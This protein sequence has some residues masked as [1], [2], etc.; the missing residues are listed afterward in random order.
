M[1]EAKY[2]QYITKNK[3]KFA[4]P[5][6]I[7][8]ECTV[9][10]SGKAPKGCGMPLY[11]E[12]GNLYVDSSDSHYF[13]KG[14]TGSKKSRVVGNNIINTILEAKENA[15]INDPKGELYRRT[16]T[17]AKEKGYN[18][19]VLNFRDVTKS[20]G[21]NPLSLAFD[22]YSNGNMPEAEQT[23]NDF[24]NAVVAPSVTSSD[25]FWSDM[26]GIV[27]AY[28]T[29]CLMDSVPIECFNMSNIIQMTHEGNASA[30]RRILME[31]DPLS[32]A[33]ICMHSVLD[34]QAARTSSC[35]YATLKQA[36]IP[37]TQNKALLELLCRRDIQLGDLV[38]PKTVI[39]IIYP[40][41][42]KSLG[43]LISLFFTQCYQYL[44]AY[45][46]QFSD[47]K[48][49][50]RVNFVLDE[51]SNLPPIDNFENCI[52]K[53]RGHNIRYFLFCQSYSQ[54]KNKYK[55]NAQTILSN[56]E[57]VVFPSKEYD[58]MEMVSRLCGKE[59]DYYGTEHDLVSVSEMQHLRKFRDGA[60]VLILKSGHYPFITKL[61]DYEHIKIFG[62]FPE[63]TFDEVKSSFTP[64]FLDFSDWVNGIGDI[65]NVPFP[66]KK[67]EVDLRYNKKG[68]PDECLG[69][70]HNA[71]NA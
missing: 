39:Y 20:S 59:Y 61:P 33:A 23:I 16:G 69:G 31:M 49:P 54:L 24:V 22:F 67:R 53:A 48:L 40:D 7:K 60:E 34:L 66:K 46:S 15:I 13:V 10:C 26:G 18:V 58:F 57:W 19:L 50:V 37:F 5:E 29:K 62:S 14:P 6:E 41:E 35:I 44:V 47:C 51:F 30:F 8:S 63:A 65:Y 17:S 64:M 4:T 32:S 71:D 56:C 42:K 28:C 25:R 11:Y 2:S 12:K 45:S 21:W 55:E 70:D 43:C 36:L 27:L 68:E 38:K 3:A 9:V 1:Y 52:S